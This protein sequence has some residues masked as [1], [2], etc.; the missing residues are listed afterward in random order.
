LES[1]HGLKQAI[2]GF[3]VVG[4]SMMLTLASLVWIMGGGGLA[5]LVALVAVL[6]GVG[7]LTIAYWGVMR[8][9]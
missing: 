1:S 6:V 8:D 7:G 2:L 4:F 9:D 3:A 5:G